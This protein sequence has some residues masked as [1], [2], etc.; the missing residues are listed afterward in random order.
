M[1][2]TI[3]F[4]F[5][6]YTLYITSFDTLSRLCPPCPKKGPHFISHGFYYA[7]LN[8]LLAM[9]ILHE[10]Y[11]MY[12][13]W[14]SF[15][16]ETAQHWTTAT[17]MGQKITL[18]SSIGVYHCI[19]LTYPVKWCVNAKVYTILYTIV[20]IKLKLVWFGEWKEKQE[21]VFF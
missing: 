1:H 2:I 14:N 9:L 7:I 21:V 17:L 6:Y 10:N 13:I 20:F 12:S 4:S 18:T 3:H 16:E 19:N 5:C 11:M 8:T 15:C